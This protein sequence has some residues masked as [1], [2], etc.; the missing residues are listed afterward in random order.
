MQLRCNIKKDIYV[1]IC[2]FV[3]V[4]MCVKDVVKN[5]RYEN[6][7]LSDLNLTLFFKSHF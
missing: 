5:S 4:C 3:C 1:F 6:R 2:L 7:F